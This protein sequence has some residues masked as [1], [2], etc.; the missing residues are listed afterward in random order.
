MSPG[1]SFC[2]TQGT[3]LDD[4]VIGHPCALRLWTAQA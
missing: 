1:G 4:E 2:A 3:I